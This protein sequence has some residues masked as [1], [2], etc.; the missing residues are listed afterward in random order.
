[1]KPGTAMNSRIPFDDYCAIDAV[2]ITRLKELGRSPQHYR[3]RLEVPKETAPLTLGRA[4][5][6]AVL[7]SERFDR[8]FVVWNK[9]TKNGSGNIAPRSGEQWESFKLENAG[10]SI[11][12]IED[13]E[14]SKAM[15]QA[16]RGNPVAM[17][18][19]ESGEPE[20]SMEWEIGEEFGLPNRRCKGRAD[21]LTR[22]DGIPHVVGLKTARDC[23]PFVFGSAAAKLNYALQ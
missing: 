9:L 13:G 18:Y 5:H 22:V 12:T 17:R 14:F 1:M 11:I 8:D 2:S 15:Q 23:R 7:E 20:V 16:V 19:L 21:W 6:C 4:A 10:R 3:Y